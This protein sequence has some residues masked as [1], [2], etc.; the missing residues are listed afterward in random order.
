MNNKIRMKVDTGANGNIIPLRIYKKMYPCGASN[1][2]GKPT[3][4]KRKARTLW[5]VNG[6]KITQYIPLILKIKRQDS[7]TIQATF[8]VCENDTEMLGLRPC[9]QLGLVQ[10]NC[11]LTKKKKKIESIDD[12]ANEYPTDSTESVS[13]QGN[14]NIFK[15]EHNTSRQSPK[16]NIQST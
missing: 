14:K 5:A 10:I 8:Y 4:I 13:F 6:I 15:R 3:A 1:E 16:E 7:P 11:S 12:L 2:M 9:I